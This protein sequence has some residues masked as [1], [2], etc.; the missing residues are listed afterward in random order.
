MHVYLFFIPEEVSVAAFGGYDESALLT[1]E[2]TTLKFDSYGMGYLGAETI[3]KMIAGVPVSKK[4]VDGYEISN[5]G[6]V[7]Y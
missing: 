2:L 6:R 1:P 3:L 4:K 5:C 7:R